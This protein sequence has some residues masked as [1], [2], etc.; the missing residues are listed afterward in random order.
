MQLIPA[1]DLRQGRVVRLEQ[2]DYER[3]TRYPEDPVELA[4]RYQDAG[5]G[6]LHLVDLDSARSGGEANLD[7]IGRICRALEI[8][9]QTGGGVRCLEDLTQRLEAGAERVVVGSLCVKRPEVICAWLDSLGGERIVA[10]LDVS[11]GVD[12]A[13]FPRASGWMEAGETDLFSLLDRFTRA[14][15]AHLLCTD[16]ERDGMFAGVSTS[17]YQSVTG[18]YAGLRVQASGGVGKPADLDAAAAT[19]VAGCIV[20]KAL[21]E[22]RVPL[23]EIKRWSQP[24]SR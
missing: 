23:S 15:L 21:L 20:G 10:G 22:G 13:W 8:P 11:R 6:C 16:I 1:I 2:G 4:L 5:A 18:R 19:G 7:I 12:G 3:E 24:W 17:L 14:G 9:V